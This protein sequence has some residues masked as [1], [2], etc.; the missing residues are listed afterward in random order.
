MIEKG[1]PGELL[2]GKV[3]EA[4]LMAGTVEFQ[5]VEPDKDRS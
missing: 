1:K 4:G 2:K 5:T 3:S